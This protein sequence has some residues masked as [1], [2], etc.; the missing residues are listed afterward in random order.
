MLLLLAITTSNKISDT[1]FS[2]HHKIHHYDPLV[3]FRFLIIAPVLEEQ[4][5]VLMGNGK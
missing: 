4:E 3:V 5:V 1:P 2:Q